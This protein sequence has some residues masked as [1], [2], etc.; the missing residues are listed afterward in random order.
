MASKAATRRSESSE[1][2]SQGMQ[3]AARPDAQQEVSRAV[4]ALHH[5]ISRTYRMWE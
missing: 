4:S 3:A 2:A 1:A 5:V